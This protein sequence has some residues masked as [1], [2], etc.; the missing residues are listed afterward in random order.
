MMRAKNSWMEGVVKAES[1]MLGFCS[2]V[3]GA[4]DMNKGFSRP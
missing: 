1:A 3:C 4:P 2:G